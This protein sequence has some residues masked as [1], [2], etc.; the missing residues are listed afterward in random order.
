MALNNFLEFVDLENTGIVSECAI[1]KRFD[2][3][4]IFYFPLNA[5]DLFDKRRLRDILYSQT[6][7][8][9]TELWKLL[10][11]H[12]L[13]NGVNALTYFNQLVKHRTAAGQIL[14]FGSGKF[15]APMQM[16]PTTR[17]QQVQPNI[18][19]QGHQDEQPAFDN[20]VKTN[21]KK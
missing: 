14:P 21:A 8:M 18:Q 9:Y 6:A 5:L 19:P 3:G 7:T 16:T 20:M 10:E 15:S 1:M 2:N 13:G 4:D 12:T 17:E 11:Q